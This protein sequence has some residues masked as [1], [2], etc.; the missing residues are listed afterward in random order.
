MDLIMKT[1]AF[2]TCMYEKQLTERLSSGGTAEDPVA[3]AISP[4]AEVIA[5]ARNGRVFILV[6]DPD[7]ENE[8]DL[9]VLAEHASDEAINFMARF[10]R[11][12]ICLA[13]GAERAA[14]LDLQLMPTRNVDKFHTAFTLS[15]DAREGITTGISAAD[16][17]RTIRLAADANSVPDDF[18]TPGHVFPLIAKPGGV[19]ERVGHTEASVDIARMTGNAAAAVICEIM[20]DD[21]TMSRLPDLAQFARIHGLKIGT[22]ADLVRYRKELLSESGGAPDSQPSDAEERD[23]LQSVPL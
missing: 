1:P 18:V 2:K 23:C 22:I 4:I 16:R 6:D 13:L 8:G 21:G 15:I 7:R 11:G 10:G 5:D 14:A 17:A 9:V 12:L 20:N 19:L 3:G